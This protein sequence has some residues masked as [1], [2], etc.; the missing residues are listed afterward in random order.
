MKKNGTK[1]KLG[2]IAISAF[3]IANMIGTGVFTSLGFQLSG[4][5]NPYAVLLL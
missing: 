1:M 2:I 5:S 3:I 4:V